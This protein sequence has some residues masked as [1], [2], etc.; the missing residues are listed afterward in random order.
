MQESRQQI[1]TADCHRCWIVRSKRA[2]SATASLIPPRRRETRRKWPRRRE[3][4]WRRNVWGR[5]NENWRKKPNWRRSVWLRRWIVSSTTTIIG[6][7][8]RCG[9]PGLSASAWTPTT[10]RTH[11]FELSTSLI[12]FSTANLLRGSRLSTI[13]ES[14]WMIR[15]FFCSKLPII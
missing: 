11:A 12:I 6:E 3:E 5:R 14:V 2:T 10:T 13:S 4:D 1:T 15:P 9:E 8:P 7:Q